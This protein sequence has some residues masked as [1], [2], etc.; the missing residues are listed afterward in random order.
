MNLRSADSSGAVGVL[1]TGGSS[2]P[3]FEDFSMTDLNHIGA[4]SG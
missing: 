4:T 2:P 3:S 1:Y